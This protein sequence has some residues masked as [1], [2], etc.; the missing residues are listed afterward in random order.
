M[1]ERAETAVRLARKDYFPDY[2]LSAGYYNMGGMPDMYT[3]RADIKLPL[4]FSRKQR[5]AVT[6]KVQS[7]SESKRSYEA[8]DQSLRFYLRSRRTTIHSWNEQGL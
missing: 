3:F 4:Y 2:T 1:I 6:E 7:L 5:A 8:A